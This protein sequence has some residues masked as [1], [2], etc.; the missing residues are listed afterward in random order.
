MAL[1]I[2]KMVLFHVSEANWFFVLIVGF[3]RQ[4]VEL[5]NS[6]GADYSHFDILTDNEVR[7]G[8]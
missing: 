8:L 2:Y 5:L 6:H 1:N 7:Q 4:I 3:S